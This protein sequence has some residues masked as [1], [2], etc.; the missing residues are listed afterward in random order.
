[1]KLTESTDK[2][3]TTTL[4]KKTNYKKINTTNSKAHET[5]CWI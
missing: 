2:S 5:C 4:T 3:L 1:M